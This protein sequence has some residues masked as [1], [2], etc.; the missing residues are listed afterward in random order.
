MT[1]L[2]S[3][4]PFSVF[5]LNREQYYRLDDTGAFLGQRVELIDGVILRKPTTTPARAHAI[6]QLSR[7]LVMQVESTGG[8]RPGCPLRVS[9]RSEPEPAFSVVS[10][11][12]LVESDHPTRAS[13]IIEVADAS[14]GFDLG[15]KADLYAAAKIPEYW[16]V[17]LVHQKL[18]VH[19]APRRGKYTRVSRF[20]RG[21][22]VTSTVAPKVTVAVDSLFR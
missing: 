13:L 15:L 17:D 7:L 8:V 9:D 6:V 22:S 12:H 4:E 1:P 18:V 11:R 3:D 10:S 2:L 16:V 20:G 14:L 21:K 5:R 19:L